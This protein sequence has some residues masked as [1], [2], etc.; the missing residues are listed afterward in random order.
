M[1]HLLTEDYKE[2]VVKEYQKRAWTVFGIGVLSVV[3]VSTIFII[4]VYVMSFGRY[5]DAQNTKQHLDKEI[6]LREDA[7]TAQNIKDI[8]SSLKALVLF[9]DKDLPST[10][11]EKLIAIKPRGIKINNIIFTPS[12]DSAT[13]LDISGVADARSNL[14]VF[15]QS[16]K[17]D[18]VFSTVDIPLSNFAKERNIEF[19]IKIL[20]NKNAK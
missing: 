19:S 8:S 4:P 17:S 18:K 15:S 14:V 12:D 6:A 2:K 5:L 1:L 3:F 10:Y 13:A 20:I 7:T 11:I 16:L 9:K